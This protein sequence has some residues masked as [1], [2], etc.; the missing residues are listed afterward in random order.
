MPSRE[1]GKVE[2]L[3]NEKGSIQ[4]KGKGKKKN[5]KGEVIEDEVVGKEREEPHNTFLRED[6]W[7]FEKLINL[8]GSKGESKGESNKYLEFNQKLEFDFFFRAKDGV[9]YLGLV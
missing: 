1:N 6:E 4:L 9:W 7:L 8:D 2:V 5:I 3:S